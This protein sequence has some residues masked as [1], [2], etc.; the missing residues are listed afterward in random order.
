MAKYE[1]VI[2]KTGYEGKELKDCVAIEDIIFEPTDE[3]VR[4]PSEYNGM[5]IECVGYRQDVIPEHVR[6][7]DWH[8][9]SQGEGDRVPTEYIAKPILYFY[10]PETV[11]KIIF[12]NTIEAINFNAF[13]HMAGKVEFVLEEGITAYKV[14]SQGKITYNYKWL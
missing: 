11:K 14:N 5:K 6:D 12:P 1:V 9:S 2:I 3:V 8:H 10:I 7:H 4:I 13:N